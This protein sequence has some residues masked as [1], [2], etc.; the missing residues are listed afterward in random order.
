MSD[1]R[2]STMT[3][4]AMIWSLVALAIG[5]ENYL[6]YFGGEAAQPGFLTSHI[7]QFICFFLSGDYSNEIASGISAVLVILIEWALTALYYGS[8][9]YIRVQE[10]GKNVNRM[11]ILSTLCYTAAGLPL[12]M[13]LWKLIC[14]L[15]ALLASWIPGQNMLEASAAWDWTFAFLDQKKFQTAFIILVDLFILWRFILFRIFHNP[16]RK[17]G[18]TILGPDGKT[19]NL[20]SSYRAGV[21]WLLGEE[22]ETYKNSFQNELHRLLW[23][24]ETARL[25]YEH[26]E[27]HPDISWTWMNAVSTH[28][29]V[30]SLNPKFAT[31]TKCAPGIIWSDFSSLCIQA[32]EGWKSR[33]DWGRAV[34]CGQMLADM[35][36]SIGLSWPYRSS[37]AYYSYVKGIFELLLAIWENGRGDVKPSPGKLAEY[38]EKQRVWKTHVHK[39][40]LSGEEMIEKEAGRSGSSSSA[41]SFAGADEYDDSSVS[42][43]E[44]GGTEAPAFQYPETIRWRDGDIWNLDF[45]YGLVA[46]YRNADTGKSITLDRLDI[47]R[48]QAS[49]DAFL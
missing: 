34:Y 13:L 19:Y 23:L 14:L 30:A 44:D 32:I 46:I 11:A 26:A 15:G 49:G 45:D 12:L 6:F 8:E 48:L 36:Y 20:P 9:S 25:G 2:Y 37:I 29:G 42:P 33:G 21:T 1:T 47:Q 31:D 24:T 39:A 4:P 27:K 38:T 17:S 28:D 5:V 41:S 40:I 16:F 35:A 3:Y 10:S 18:N 22:A 7:N 43:Q